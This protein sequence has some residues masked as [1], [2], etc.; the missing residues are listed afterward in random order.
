MH[1]HEKTRN[2]LIDELVKVRQRIAASKIS[3]VK[4]RYLEKK[5]EAH[6]DSL[7]AL[8]DT[9]IDMINQLG[10]DE[11]MEIII[12]RVAGLVKA[13]HGFFYLYNPDSGVLELKKA[14]GLYSAH[15]GYHVTH[16]AGLAGKVLQT[17]RAMAVN[18]YQSWEGRHPDPRWN[19]IRAITALPLVFE[20]QIM[21]VMGFVHTE[22]DR[23]KFG[24]DDMAVLTCFA[25]LA[26]IALI[27]A[28][29]STKLQQELERKKL[30]EKELQQ[31]HEHLQE[32]FVATVNALAS[33]VE[34]KDLY[35]AA[36]QRWVTR[37]AC[38]IAAEMDLSKEQIE[39]V[40]MAGLIH[41]IGKM[42][43]PAELLNKPGRLSDIEYDIIK[44]HPQ[45]GYDI[46]REIQFPWP[47]A[48]I[49]LQHHERMDGSGYPQRLSG[50]Q[51]LLEARLLAVADVVESM[52]SPRPYRDAYGIEIALEE[53]SKN[54][55]TLYDTEVVDAC[56]RVFQEKG[57][58]FEYMDR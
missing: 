9:I 4:P 35:T 22:E 38:A 20:G 21:G 28:R 26:N 6:Y 45:S 44:I 58:T 12:T 56:L 23:K 10:V 55:G 57:F 50:M 41:D 48:Q 17:G 15:I 54:R 25:A 13:N 18:D 53:I 1:G 3:E 40:R 27:N 46:V 5:I 39:G 29:L 14:L 49:V 36:H 30:T 32:T 24:K 52:A 19:P 51:I 16:G 43:V 37:L 8:H 2:Q 33:T 11:F 47:V 34:L 7:L 42:N 31:G